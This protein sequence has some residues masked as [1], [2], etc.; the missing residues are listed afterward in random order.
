MNLLDGIVPPPNFDIQNVES[1]EHLGDNL[2]VQL[3]TDPLTPPPAD[4]FE[5]ERIR[6]THKSQMTNETVVWGRCP[7][8]RPVK[9]QLL[10][11]E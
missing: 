9:V 10:A 11:V 2:L 5:G 4:N 6:P 7:L 1:D 3:G 8:P